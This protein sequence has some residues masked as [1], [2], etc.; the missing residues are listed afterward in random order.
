[1]ENKGLTIPDEFAN[2]TD[3][4]KRAVLLIREALSR[5]FADLELK[6]ADGFIVSATLGLK[7]KF[8]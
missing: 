3:E 2:L 4:E 5:K 1:M 8:R 6:I 7:H